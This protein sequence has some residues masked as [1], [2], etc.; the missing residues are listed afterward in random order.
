MKWMWSSMDLSIFVDESGDFDLNSKHSPYYIYT[1]VLHNQRKNITGEILKLDRHM[2]EKKFGRHAIHTAPLIRREKPYLYYN[3]EERKVL[4]NQL[5]Y[6]TR[7]CDINYHSFMFEKKEYDT[8]E[9]LVSKMAQE[10]ALF[11]RNN[12]DYFS[13]FDTVKVYYDNGQ[14]E[15]SQILNVS[16]NILLSNV[17]IKKVY[18]IDYKLFQVAD[19]LCTIELLNIKYQTKTLSKSETS[20]FTTKEIK[21][22]IKDLNKK[23]M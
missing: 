17:I 22:M 5:Y 6:F 3:Y 2:E 1:L 15:I 19:L 10:L 14:T 7:S 12:L 13:S 16:L 8:K 11:I 20:F 9:K 23:K 21:T 18:P 4:F